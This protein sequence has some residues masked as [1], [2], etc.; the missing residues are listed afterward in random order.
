LSSGRIDV[1]LVRLGAVAIVISAFYQLA[2]YGSYFIESGVS[3]PAQIGMVILTVLLPLGIASVLWKFPA[4]V[5]RKVSPELQQEGRTL[6]EPEELMI[7]GIALLGLYTFVSGTLEV[8]HSESLAVWE[9]SLVDF[10]QSDPYH[11]PPNQLAR[12][13]TSYAEVAFGIVLMFGRKGIARLI[14]NAR[15]R[16]SVHKTD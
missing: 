4:S 15:G 7:V 3:V 16:Q 2:G 1:V 13:L 12:R 9:R 6:V 11:S 5:V 14:L 8:L 10:Y